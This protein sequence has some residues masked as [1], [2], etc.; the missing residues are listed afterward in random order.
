VKY[1]KTIIETFQ[2]VGLTLNPNGSEDHKLKIKGLDDI[3]VGD[4]RRKELDP[5]DGLGSLTAIDVAAVEAAQLKL[6]ER[7]AKVKAKRAAKIVSLDD[8]TES[9]D[10]E[11]EHEEVFTLGRMGTRSQTQVNRYYAADEAEEG[12]DVDENNQE[13]MEVVADGNSDVDD[14]PSE[15]DPSDD[16]E[17]NE[18]VNGDSDIMDESM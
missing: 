15:F 11:E 17:Y 7:V 4:F 16:E 8:P 3:K 6:K 1:K 18:S 13:S 10:D 14:E 12:P 5:E 2:R 9:S